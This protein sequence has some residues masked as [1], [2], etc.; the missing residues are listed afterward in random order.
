MPEIQG[1]SVSKTVLSRGPKAVGSGVLVIHDFETE[2]KK[3]LPGDM[4]ESKPFKVKDHWFALHVYP[5]GRIDAQAG[6][7]CVGMSNRSERKV[8]VS[9]ITISDGERT[10]HYENEELLEE[11]G[12]DSAVGWNEWDRV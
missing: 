2:M 6:Y 3:C 10:E 9:K 8:S 11:E 12:L 1:V 7:I 5:N 4:L